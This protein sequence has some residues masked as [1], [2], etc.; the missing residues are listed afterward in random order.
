MSKLYIALYDEKTGMFRADVEEDELEEIPE[1]PAEG[2]M[3]GYILKTGKSL[4]LANPDIEDMISKGITGMVGI[5]PQQWL[6]VPLKIENKVIGVMVVQSYKS[7]RYDKATF[8]YLE[9]VANQLSV[10]IEKRIEE[11]TLKLSKAIEQSP[12]VLMLQILKEQ[13]S[14]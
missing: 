11:N 7:E 10:F 2:S 5:I 8:E 9:T 3:S 12:S 6:G 4:M 14:I 13:S 1:W